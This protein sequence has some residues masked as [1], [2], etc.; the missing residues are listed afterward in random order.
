MVEVGDRELTGRET[1]STD[2]LSETTARNMA[3]KRLQRKRKVIGDAVAYVVINAFLV[4]VWAINDR[5]YFWPGWVLAGWGTLLLLDIWN[6]FF[7]KQITEADIEREL[8][9]RR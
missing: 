6:A 4:V 7:R 3:V 2:A 8:G 9:A 5:S 1:S